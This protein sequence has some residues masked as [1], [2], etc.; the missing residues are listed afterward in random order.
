MK[1]FIPLAVSNFRTL[2]QEAI[3]N[4]YHGTICAFYKCMI[5]AYTT[6]ISV[7]DRATIVEMIKNGLAL[8]EEFKADLE[9]LI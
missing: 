8:A 2:A 6:N 4:T 7:N 5:A 1:F 3:D 9:K